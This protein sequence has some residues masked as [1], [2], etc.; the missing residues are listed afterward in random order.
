[1]DGPFVGNPLV[2]APPPPAF[3]IARME[4]RPCSTTKGTTCPICCEDFTPDDSVSVVPRCGHVYHGER[5][6]EL[7]EAK[8]N[9]RALKGDAPL[10]HVCEAKSYPTRVNLKAVLHAG[11]GKD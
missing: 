8:L 9:K 2:I 6:N 4:E 10:F 11:R 1:M 5:L 3:S 7:I